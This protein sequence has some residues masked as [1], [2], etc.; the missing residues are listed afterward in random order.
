MN[1]RVM[2]KWRDFGRHPYEN[3][4]WATQEVIMKI[5]LPTLIAAIAVAGV[6]TTAP[7]DPMKGHTIVPPQE[8]KWGPA[9][10]V[11]PAGAEAAVLFGDRVAPHTH[12]VDEVITV[13]SGTFRMGMGQS[14]DQR[15][16][17]ALPAGSFFALPPGTAHY[18]FTKE[19]TV[20]QISTNGPW[21]LTYI[22][23][24]DYPRQ[25]SQ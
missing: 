19:E 9:P 3:T 24:K 8:I 10:A 20:I 23:P 4:E 21:G 14:A 13:I 25:K 1:S 15:K 12:P 2:S 16:A 18:V 5:A 6:A 22:N 11:L 17:Q 7:A